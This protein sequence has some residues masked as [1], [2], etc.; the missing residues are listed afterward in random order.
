MLA[1]RRTLALLAALAAIAVAPAAASALTVYGAS[2]LKTVV[3]A[4]A[5][6]HTYSWG[7]SDTLELQISNG[8]PADVFLSAAPIYANA[9]H[10]AGRCGAP[11]EFARNTLAFVVPTANPGRIADVRDLTTRGGYRLAM[12][13]RTVPIGIY[14]RTALGKMGMPRVLLKNT[15]ASYAKATDILTALALGN[16][17]AGFVYATDYFANRDALRRLPIPR[18]AQ[19]LIRYVACAVRP[20]AAAAA[21]IRR[22]QRADARAALAAAHFSLPP[23]G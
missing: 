8:A 4:L 6:G 22:P 19:P 14:A 1:A 11:V 7:G 10:D 21:F 23:T 12:G 15:V 9:L 3:P 20:S 13:R 2:S 16:A 5:P 17:D 18:S